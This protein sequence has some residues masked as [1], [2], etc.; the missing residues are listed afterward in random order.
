M[1]QFLP[2]TVVCYLSEIFVFFLFSPGENSS[3]PSSS[4]MHLVQNHVLQLLVVDRS[5]VDV[6]LQRFSEDKRQKHMIGSKTEKF[7]NI[8]I[9][10]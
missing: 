1:L 2:Y 9:L 10:P 3:G 8:K 5:E 7:N 4:G 6:R